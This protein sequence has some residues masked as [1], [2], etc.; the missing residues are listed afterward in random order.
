MTKPS[1]GA[2]GG[3]HLRRSGVY[4]GSCARLAAPEVE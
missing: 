4:R 3:Q 2:Q 1:I